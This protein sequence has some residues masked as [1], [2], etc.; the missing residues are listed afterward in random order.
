MKS[1]WNTKYELLMEYT[2]LKTWN[3]SFENSQKMECFQNNSQTMENAIGKAAYEA[4]LL[5][6]VVVYI[7]EACCCI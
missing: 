1:I 6:I 3:V 2:I 7:F 5:Y 4:C